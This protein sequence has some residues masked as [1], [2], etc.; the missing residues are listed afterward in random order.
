MLK[1]LL[2]SSKSVKI[3]LRVQTASKRVK[4]KKM[5]NI[6][7]FSRIQRAVNDKEAAFVSRKLKPLDYT[8][9][10]QFWKL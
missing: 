2:T 9:N 8:T 5:K 10:T 7:I 1:F 4:S 6:S 3:T